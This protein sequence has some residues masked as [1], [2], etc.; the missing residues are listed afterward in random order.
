[1]VSDDS[2]SG[3]FPLHP[4]ACQRIDIVIPNHHSNSIRVAFLRLFGVGRSVH[5]VACDAGV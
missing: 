2:G 1:M 3:E 5:N 4:N